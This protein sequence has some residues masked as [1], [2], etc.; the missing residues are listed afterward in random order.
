MPSALSKPSE[1]A[2]LAVGPLLR[3]GAKRPDLRTFGRWNWMTSTTN[4]AH[5]APLV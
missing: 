1:R 3:K 4:F 2:Y 5:F